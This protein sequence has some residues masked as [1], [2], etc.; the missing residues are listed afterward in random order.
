MSAQAMPR[1]Q[2]R[3][4]EERAKLAEEVRERVRNA[5]PDQKAAVD[6]LRAIGQA[7]FAIKH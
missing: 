2:P 1:F 7:K 6:L 5:T 3:T 4:P